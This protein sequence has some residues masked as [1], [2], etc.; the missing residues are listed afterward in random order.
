M[1]DVFLD[2]SPIKKEFCLSNVC[3][4][5]EIGRL[6][7]VPRRMFGTS[8]DRRFGDS[9]FLVDLTR[10]DALSVRAINRQAAHEILG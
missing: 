8:Q 1:S 6:A 7:G 2:H 10:H 3:L 5:S 4:G 9:V